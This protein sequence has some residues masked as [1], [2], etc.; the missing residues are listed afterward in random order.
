MKQKRQ[1]MLLAV[2]L[3]IAVAVW[4]FYFQQGK[5]VVTAEAGTSIRNVRLLSVENPHIRV[6]KLESPR[7]TEYKSLGRNIFTTVAPLEIPHV[8]EKHE[9][10][11]VTPPV[12]PPPPPPPVLPVKF[13]GYGTVPYGSSRRAFLYSTEDEK[14]YIVPEGEILMNRY[15][16]L[17]INNTNLEFEEISSGRRG[18]AQLEEQA[19]GPPSA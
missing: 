4:L 19:G 1:L 12:P 15:R 5:P 8:E 3:V 7:K 17:K 6:E 2:L 9:Y 10:P 13:F 14:V 16:I 18:T 11:T